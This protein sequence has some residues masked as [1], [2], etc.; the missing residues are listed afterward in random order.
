MS[1]TPEPVRCS[2]ASTPLV[3][4]TAFLALA[5]LGPAASAAHTIE[6]DETTRYQTIE[7]WGA[8]L[9]SW[10]EMAGPDSL[11][12][13]PRFIRAYARE[14]G[15]NILR[16]ACSTHALKGP[17]GELDDAVH[18]V[19]DVQ[20]NIG[21]YNFEHGRSRIF[22]QVAN[23][24]LENALEPERV[25]FMA[26]FW[27]PPHWM[28]G[29]TGAEQSFA[30]RPPRPTPFV[31]WQGSNTV[32]GRLK[33]TP[34]NLEQFGRYVVA[35]TRGFEQHYGI[36]FDNISL[37]NELSFENPFDSC[38]YLDKLGP[39]K[40]GDGDPDPVGGQYWQYASALKAV[41]TEF[42]EKGITTR[43][44]GPHMGNVGEKPSNPWALND[45]C[46][47]VRAVM[48]H[49]DPELIDF[50][51]VYTSNYI[52][53]QWGAVM[54]R[55]FREGKGAMPGQDWA[56]WLYCPGFGY[57]KPYWIAEMGG[58]REQWLTGEDGTPGRGAIRVAHNIHNA[59]VWGHVSAYVY[60]Q[61][62]SGGS[63]TP[64]GGS[65]LGNTLDASGGKASAF[66][67]FSRWIRPGAVRVA[68]TPSSI[69]GADPMDTGHSLNVSA[70]VHDADRTV[71]VV[72]VNLLPGEQEVSIRVPA[73]PEADVYR[74]WRSSE[75]ERFAPQPDLPVKDGRVTLTIP[76][77]TVLTLHGHAPE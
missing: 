56:S 11:Y 54:L 24:L 50:L 39:D 76:R 18:L 47:F 15:C 60:W 45:Q 41:K 19:D 8:C 35:W 68:A 53:P 6:V 65:L 25:K 74:V 70:Y 7:G 21:K 37:Q 62:V 3:L 77:Y 30:G 10:G 29:P 71:T 59:M 52:D 55:A 69:G 2:A 26:D 20:E 75:G 28:K 5:F 73:E 67:H 31:T 4:A 33:Q 40:D 12:H 36:T 34:E 48:E 16:I 43:I 72:L 27:S 42:E 1:S 14:L 17:G 23:Y 57:E 51:D 38:T 32:G 46:N 63:S 66:R 22:G 58:A 13:D 49:E 64:G 9:V 44:R 61:A